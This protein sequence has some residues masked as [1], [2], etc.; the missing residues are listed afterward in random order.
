M[1]RKL[2]LVGLILML[3]TGAI[4]FGSLAHV[5]NTVL[6][7]GSVEDFAALKGW[8]DSIIYRDQE[9]RYYGGSRYQAQEYLINSDEG[10]VLHEQLGGFQW[11]EEGVRHYALLYVTQPSQQ[12]RDELQQDPELEY[13]EVALAKCD[14]SLLQLQE[15]LETLDAYLETAPASVRNSIQTSLISPR[16]NRVAIYVKNWSIFDQLNL[17]KAMG[18]MAERLFIVRENLN[19]MLPQMEF[20]HYDQWRLDEEFRDWTLPEYGGTAKPIPAEIMTEAGKKMES[21]WYEY[22]FCMK[23]TVGTRNWRTAGLVDG[24]GYNSFYACLQTWSWKQIA[25]L[26]D[27]FDRPAHATEVL[28]V[29]YEEWGKQQEYLTK[30]IF[31]EMA[32]FQYPI[33]VVHSY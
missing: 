28:Y 7:G 17:A 20:F 24:A 32:D 27:N 12:L 5:A 9:K 16:E 19:R 25:R 26:F 6:P 33:V 23:F 15:A 29:Y 3:L 8:D 2:I 10:S 1:K 22:L 13:M 11:M 18:T 14:Y 21:L 30:A 4:L 31:H